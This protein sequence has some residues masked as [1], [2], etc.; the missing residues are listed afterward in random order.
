M[1]YSHV[2]YHNGT[3]IK[4]THEDSLYIFTSHFITRVRK[5]YS[6]F[7]CERV[8]EIVH[9]C[10]VLT[11]NLW[12]STLCLSFFLYAQPEAL[13]STL[14]G[15]GFH[16]CI[17]SASSLDPNSIRA[18]EGPFGRVW[19]FLPYL[20]YLRLQLYRNSNCLDWAI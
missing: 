4:Q 9:N 18:P 16:Y 6:R 19:L 2:P 20:V 13:G 11:P 14:L 10:D 12:P 7:A 8:L 5:G 17:L 15:A 3:I 1:F